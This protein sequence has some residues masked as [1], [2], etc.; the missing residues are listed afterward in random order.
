M[1]SN[2]KGVLL[3]A[4]VMQELEQSLVQPYCGLI[5]FLI[6]H[7]DAAS[8]GRRKN[9]PAVGTEEFIRQGA[10]IFLSG[11]SKRR[12][13]PPGTI[14]DEMVSFILE[15][16]FDVPSDELDDAK[17]YHLLSMAAENLVGDLL[18][19]Y[20]APIMESAGWIWCSGA[21]VKAVDF[22][23][24]P[25]SS[26]THWSLLQV[27]NRDNSENSSSAAIRD[28]TKITK[29]FRTFS[30]KPQDNWDAFPDSH[31]RS[32]VSESEFRTFVR[33]YFREMKV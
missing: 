25:S 10:Q 4:D 1:I 22:I 21:M 13:E 16:Y 29:W 3:A 31:V 19:Q 5:D 2:R 28:G 14:P 17:R 9:S 33:N 18:E 15:T 8:K 23:K 32:L 24:P 27:K 26:S 30:K 11:R 6:D 20:L 7:P 12:P